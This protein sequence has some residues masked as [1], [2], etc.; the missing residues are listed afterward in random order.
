VQNA[1]IGTPLLFASR[2]DFCDEPVDKTSRDPKLV[3]HRNHKY[4]SHFRSI[5][6]GTHDC[7]SR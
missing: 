5:G 1:S 7:S 4:L 6:E 3:A 2:P